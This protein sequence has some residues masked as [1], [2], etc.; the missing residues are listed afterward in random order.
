MA[1]EGGGWELPPEMAEAF[2]ACGQ[3]S[4]R[5][6]MA[7]VDRHFPTLRSRND[8]LAML[9]HVLATVAAG[10]LTCDGASPTLYAEFIK[11]LQEQYRQAALYDAEGNA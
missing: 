7:A 5:Y 6:F 9:L 10:A 1:E 4:L 3:E 8:K 11:D 2:D